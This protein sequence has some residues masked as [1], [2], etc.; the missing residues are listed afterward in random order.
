MRRKHKHLP[1]VTENP[2]SENQITAIK[3]SWLVQRKP[4]ADAV[5]VR[6]GHIL[7]CLCHHRLQRSLHGKAESHQLSRRVDCQLHPACPSA[8]SRRKIAFVLVPEGTI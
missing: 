7:F 6:K 5:F 1:V 3:T 2:D 8:S 4:Q